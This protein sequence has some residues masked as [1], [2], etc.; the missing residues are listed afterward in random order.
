MESASA[1]KWRGR[2]HRIFVLVSVFAAAI[3]ALNSRQIILRSVRS[4]LGRRSANGPE[5]KRPPSI[6]APLNPVLAEQQYSHKLHNRQIKPIEEEY[7]Q[8]S[9]R[10]DWSGVIDYF[11]NGTTHAMYRASLIEA[12]Y[13]S[14]QKNIQSSC[15]LV[16]IRNGK[17]T[18]TE[19]Y[20]NRHGR[21]ASVKY[22][23]GK[24]VREQGARIADCTF[25]V[26]LTDGVRPKVITFGSARHWT[27]WRKMIP[28]PLGNFR[29]HREGWG[30]PIR[31][32][33]RYIDRHV[34]STH[35]L[36]PWKSKVPKAVFR[37]SL[38][39]QTYKLGSCNE[40]R[41]FCVRAEKWSEVNRGVLYV[42]SRKQPHLFDVEFS[43]LKKKNGVGQGQFN[44]APRSRKVLKFR[45]FQLYKYIL[46]VGSNQGTCLY[47]VQYYSVIMCSFTARKIV[48]SV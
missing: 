13:E 37:G 34:T 21:A 1:R 18:F 40:G 20:G 24:I 17:V 12:H 48:R 31:D 33:D 26:M 3:G 8:T 22:I 6:T 11:M 44:G 16:K 4:P 41:G 42:Q 27:S 28:A 19:K 29:G 43:Q 45:D 15:M 10:E 23:L 35:H 39:M 9:V 14:N 38:V 7:A 30:N 47:L 5:T 2:K 32:W 46:N 36:Y 25:L